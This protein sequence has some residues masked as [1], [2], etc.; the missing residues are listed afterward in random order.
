[1]QPGAD[2]DGALFGELDRVG[3]QV[4][5]HLAQ[6]HGVGAHGGQVALHLLNNLDGLVAHQPRRGRDHAGNCIGHV[7]F[8][9]GEFH[10]AG[11]DFREVEDVVDEAEQVLTGVVNRQQVL[12]LLFG[13]GAVY[14]LEDDAR[15]AD[16]GVERGTQFVRHVRQEL[17]L[18]DVHLLQFLPCSFAASLV[19]HGILHADRNLLGQAFQHGDFFRVEGV[20]FAGVNIQRADDAR[21]DFERNAGLGARFRQQR[22]GT[23]ERVE[24]GVVDEERRA[25]AGDRADD[26]SRRDQDGVLL[27]LD[28]A[29]ASPGASHSARR[30]AVLVYGEQP[31]EVVVKRAR[32]RSTARLKRGVH[33]QRN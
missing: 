13:D 8:L 5:Q 29:P 9:E 31:D 18:D 20:D 30:C 32:I 14:A 10:L 25:S 12:L 7:E 27:P 28:C 19:R 1:M 24:R 16:D 22:V 6:T 15:E 2:G 11:F 3:N 21:A 23:V 26:R 4:E 33:I 17:A